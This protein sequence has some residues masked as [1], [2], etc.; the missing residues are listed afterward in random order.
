MYKVCF[1][2]LKLAMTLGLLLVMFKTVGFTFTAS[3]GWWMMVTAIHGIP[4]RVP[5]VCLLLEWLGFHRC[6]QLL[7]FASV[8]VPRGRQ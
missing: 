7:E 1:E 8:F 3:L 5:E 2:Y 4:E 6:S